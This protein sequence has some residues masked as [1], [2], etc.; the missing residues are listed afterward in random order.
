MS[1]S[2]PEKHSWVPGDEVLDLN[3]IEKVIGKMFP[4][5]EV[6]FLNLEIVKQNA[7]IIEMNYKMLE[8][9]NKPFGNGVI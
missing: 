3:E 8:W 7:M 6:I 1:D 2:Q 5:E 4:D 9:L